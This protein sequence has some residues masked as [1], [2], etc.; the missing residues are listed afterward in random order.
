MTRTIVTTSVEETRDLAHAL[1]ERV[2]PGDVIALI[3]D[4]GVGKT[5][6]V[7]GLAL[8]LGIPEAVPIS[9]PTFTI[10]A[11]H[12]EGRIPLYHFDVYRLAGPDDFLSLGFDE[13]LDGDG[14][15][16]IEWADLVVGVLRGDRLD[17]TLTQLEN[18]D[19]RLDL[20]SYGAASDR[21]LEGLPSA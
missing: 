3:G 20:E 17:I 16:V 18:G 7:Q 12:A 9:S 8:G 1:G 4:L 15:S 13:Y 19:R 10:I 11:E 2:R 6:F 14:V 5:A 21:L